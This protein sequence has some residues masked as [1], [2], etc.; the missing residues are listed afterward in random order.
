MLSSGFRL[1]RG[2][3]TL[4]PHHRRRTLADWKGLQDFLRVCDCSRLVVIDDDP[5]G[6]QTMHNVDVLLEHSVATLQSQLQQDDKPFFILTNSR[7]LTEPQA[8]SITRTVMENLFKAKQQAQYPKQ[9]RIVSRSDSTLRGHFA[10]EVNSIKASTLGSEYDGVV[11]CP[12][13]FEGNRYTIDN[14]HYLMD[15]HE[16][17]PV[18]ETP[19][20]NDPHFGFTTS[21]LPTYLQHKDKALVDRSVVCVS[22]EDLRGDRAVDIVINKLLGTPKDGVVVVNGKLKRHTLYTIHHTPYTIYHTATKYSD[23]VTF[24]KG[25]VAAEKGKGKGEGGGRRFLIRS[26]ASILPPLCGI[27]PLPPLTKDQLSPMVSSRHGGGG[28]GVG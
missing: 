16:L 11:F 12:A 20:A 19:F 1:L 8:A 3:A 18:S 7:S 27:P 23:L 26:A 10:A 6:C 21:H 15:R 28:G 13:F 22:L 5:T 4:P 9:L 14:F 17:V 25:L 2:K 24:T